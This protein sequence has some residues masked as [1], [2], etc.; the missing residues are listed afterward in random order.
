MRRRVLVSVVAA[1]LLAVLV[2]AAGGGGGTVDIATGDIGA[3]PGDPGSSTSSDGGSRDAS[4]RSLDA[5]WMTITPADGGSGSPDGSASV[6]GGVQRSGASGGGASGH[7]DQRGPGGATTADE[8]SRPTGAAGSVNPESPHPAAPATPGV[9]T[10]ALGPTS[11]VPGT[12]TTVP[13]RNECVGGAVAHPSVLDRPPVAFPDDGTVIGHSNG[14]RFAAELVRHEPGWVSAARS[15]LDASDWVANI[16]R[17]YSR[18]IAANPDARAVVVVLS[19]RVTDEGGAY[20]TG[21]ALTTFEVSIRSLV[22]MLQRDLPQLETIILR[23][24]ET[25][26]YTT[27]ASAQNGEPWTFQHNEIMRDLADELAGVEFVNVWDAEGPACRQYLTAASF[28]SGG[29][30]PNTSG[31]AAIWATFD[32]QLLR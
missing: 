29:I 15:S 31:A 25:G 8:T 32:R 13:Q 19:E 12:P 7:G 27:A 20:P 30:H 3:S 14:V 10:P 11:T 9:T 24:R 5:T 23:S 2:L 18:A 26:R 22:T 28:E 6:D 16:D 1:S 21:P 17:V 4:E